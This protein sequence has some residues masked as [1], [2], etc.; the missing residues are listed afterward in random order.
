MTFSTIY[1]M[2]SVGQGVWTPE[3]PLWPHDR[4]PFRLMSS[5]VT[6]S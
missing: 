5:P 3:C 6:L 2:H 1:I 4:A